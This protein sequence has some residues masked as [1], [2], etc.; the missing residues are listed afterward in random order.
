MLRPRTGQKRS[1]TGCAR[2]VG[3]DQKRK[4]LQC[5]QASGMG[6]KA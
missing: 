1:S 5:K 4:S 2:Q 3:Q 6:A